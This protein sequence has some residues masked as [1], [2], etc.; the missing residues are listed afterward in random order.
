MARLNLGGCFAAVPGSTEYQKTS[1]PPPIA[2]INFRCWRMLLQLSGDRHPLAIINI[3]S[4]LCFVVSTATRPSNYYPARPA[5]SPGQAS[6]VSQCIHRASSS[7][8]RKKVAIHR[9][10]RHSLAAAPV[11]RNTASALW[12]A[13]RD[14][15]PLLTERRL[16]SLA[17]RNL[18]TGVAVNQHHTLGGFLT[19]QSKSEQPCL[20]GVP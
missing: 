19:S 17:Q 10:D 2:G 11:T 12:D 8:A 1:L 4:L 14:L 5:S 18:D 20:I 15:T 16:D 3:C 9:M 6:L 7:T 13:D